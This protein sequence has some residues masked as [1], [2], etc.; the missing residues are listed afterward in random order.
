MHDT[1]VQW[2]KM[3]GCAIFEGYGMT[4]TSPVVSFNPPG[5]ERLGTIGIPAPSTEVK[6][7]D[8]EGNALAIG[9]I[10]ELCIRGPQVMEG[11]WQNEQETN[12]IINAEKWLLSGDIACISED[13]YITL[14]DRKKDMIIVS[15]FNVYPNEIEDV[16]TDFPTVT[17]CAA[18]GV[19]NGDTGETI[20]VFIVASKPIEEAELIAFCRQRLT[21]Y[22]IPKLFEFRDEL[23]KT[24]VGKVLRRALRE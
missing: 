15:G 9:E 22:K 8:D 1:A 3:T 14:I 2:Q 18:I 7:I 4:E 20:K 13:G 11:Y 16:V 19:K 21:G 10:G 5:Y 23:P 17:E 24:P 6:I 12:H